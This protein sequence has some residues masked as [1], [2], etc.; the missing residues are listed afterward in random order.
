MHFVQDQGEDLCVSNSLASALFELGF[1][2]EATKIASYGKEEL[3]RGTVNALKKVM[4]FA[5]EVLPKWIKPAWK[6]RNF[7]WKKE[8]NE[9]VALVGVLL[10]S[11][12]TCNPAVTIHGGFIYDANEPVAIPLCQD[13]LDFCTST[14][15][16][17]STFIE[18][19]QGFMLRYVGGKQ[20][21]VQPMTLPSKRV[22]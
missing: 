15:T 6:P 3:A 17:K 22:K 11:D 14:S 18:F 7:D 9:T 20:N 12:G 13:A 16:G 19:R 4:T 2:V 1:A 5:S 21:K 10:A 8:L